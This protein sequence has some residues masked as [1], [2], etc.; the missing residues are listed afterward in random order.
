MIWT[1]EDG[2]PQTWSQGQILVPH[3]FGAFTVRM[4]EV[5]PKIDIL[6]QVMMV[7]DRG[8]LADGWV[9]VDDFEF[10]YGPE[11][12]PTSPA[13]TPTPSPPTCKDDQLPCGDGQGCF[14]PRQ[15]CDFAPDCKDNTDE[16][17]CPK[18]YYFDDCKQLTGSQNCGWEELAHDALDWN[19]CSGWSMTSIFCVSLLTQKMEPWDLL[20]R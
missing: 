7:A 4:T 2:A 17:G 5:K 9:A 6:H 3:S 15:R 19:L 11:E 14:T 1:H 16:L 18:E 13:P 10:L 12:C 20:V 8:E